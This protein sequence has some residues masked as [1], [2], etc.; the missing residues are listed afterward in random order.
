M[1]IDIDLTF[2]RQYESEVH[3]TF[4]QEGSLLMNHVVSKGPITGKSTT[5]QKIGKGKAMQKTRGGQTPLMNLDHTP[6]ECTLKD[7]YA[8]D[9]VDKLDEL[10]LFHNE[11]NAVTRSGAA[12]L[13]REVDSFIISDAL[14]QTTQFVGDF[15]TGLSRNLVL[16]ALQKLYDTGIRPDGRICGA[17]TPKAWTELMTEAEFSSSDFVGHDGQ[18][19]KVGALSM[20]RWLNVNWIMHTGLPLADSDNRS[21]FIWHQ[22]AVGHAYG[23]NIETVISY[24]NTLSAFLINLHMSMGACLIDETGV[25]EI[26]V[27]DDASLAN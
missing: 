22:D 2:I 17:I 7:R 25:V 18:P 6:I 1:S 9:L 4:Q 16:G 24:E 3:K 21:C 19:Y 11:R 10:K 14:A 27:D 5:F 23:N 12:A 20:Q 15:S 8:A 13:G 26:R